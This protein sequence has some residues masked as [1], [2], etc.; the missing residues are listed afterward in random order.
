MIKTPREDRRK[1]R[2]EKVLVD[3]EFF[4]VCRLSIII[5]IRQ[6]REFYMTRSLKKIYRIIANN[7]GGP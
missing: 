4:I 3:E 5:Y 7:R 6:K 2:N 1:P